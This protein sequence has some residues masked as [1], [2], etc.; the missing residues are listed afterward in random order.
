MPVPVPFHKITLDH[1]P[2]LVFN[3][4]LE[5]YSMKLDLLTNATVVNDPVRFLS[6]HNN[7]EKQQKQPISNINNNPLQTNDNITTNKVF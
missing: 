5:F 4:L 1:M 6:E 2:Y 7:N 3:P